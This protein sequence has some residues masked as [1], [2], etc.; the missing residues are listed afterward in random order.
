MEGILYKHYRKKQRLSG[1]KSRLKGTERTIEMIRTD[2]KECNVDLHD[3]L[4]AINY[5]SDR[6]QNNSTTSSIE[7]ELERATDIM[8]KHIAI[9]IKEKYQLKN[10]INTLEKEI[11]NIDIQLEKLTE[12]ELQI[13]ELRYGEKNNYRDMENILHMSR[14]TLQRKKDK[15][16]NY[17]MEELK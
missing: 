4:K 16:I 17:L 14:S 3:T 11:S 7:L 2:I 15:L 10:K 13:V 9:N 12:E 6:I 8:L 1:L 5:S